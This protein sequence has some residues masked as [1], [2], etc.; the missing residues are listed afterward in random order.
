MSPGIALMLIAEAL[1]IG[2]IVGLN[3][4]SKVCGG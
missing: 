1:L 2:G 3:L 4:A